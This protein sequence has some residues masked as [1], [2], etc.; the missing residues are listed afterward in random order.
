MMHVDTKTTI[1][2]QNPA[3]WHR[4]KS[5]AHSSSEWTETNSVRHPVRP[6][7]E[8]GVLYQR[9]IPTLQ[10]TISFEILEIDKHLDIF[11]Q[12]QN[13]R[14]VYKFWELNKPK[15][16]LRDY[17][18]KVNADPHHFPLIA[19]VDGVP[20]GYFE[21]Y[22]AAE[23]RIG[24]FYDCEPFDRGL[25]FL[26]GNPRHLGRDYF[27]SFVES[28]SHYLFLSDERTGTLLAEPRSDNNVLLHYLSEFPYWEH[29]YDFDFPH[30]RASLLAC[31]REDFFKMA[32]FV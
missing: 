19:A 17:L 25:H 3:H 23:D 5:K 12:W 27:N 9:F 6:V 13:Q 26:I 14:R 15:E 2:F 7:E 11:H 1:D 22:W 18:E 10:K 21:I 29:R 31:R 30:K 24:P 20:S 8:P 16:E 32:S 28:I 4:P